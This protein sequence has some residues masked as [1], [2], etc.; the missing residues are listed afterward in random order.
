[1]ETMGYSSS[2]IRCYVSSIAALSLHYNKQPDL[3]TKEEIQDY[4]HYCIKEKA[5]SRSMINQIIGALKFFHVHTLGISW[6]SKA[7]PRPRREKHL[8]VVFS[9]SEVARFLGAFK[10]M[11]HK[12]LFT[13]MYSSGLRVGELRQL[14]I[15]D[16]DSSRMQLRIEQS[17]GNKDRY[18]ILSEH[19]LALLR[20]Y[21]KLYKP[22]FWLFENDTHQQMAIRTIQQVMHNTLKKSGIR[23]KASPHTLRHS[24]ATHMLEQGTPLHIVQHLLGH[25]RMTTTFGYIHLQQYDSDQVK[26]PID[27]WNV[28]T[29]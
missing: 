26:S 19:A 1:M 21:Y 16:V 5:V 25:S 7:F 8:P 23:K 4:L 28:H 11:K 18:S 22:H 12:A 10:N 27:R 13:L 29:A 2:T 6:D 17:K 24:F 14:K 3:L 9:Q 20:T 15:T